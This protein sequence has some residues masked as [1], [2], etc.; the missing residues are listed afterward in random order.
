MLTLVYDREE[1]ALTRRRTFLTSE[2]Q[3]LMIITEKREGEGC[4]KNRGPFKND[5]PRR[6]IFVRATTTTGWMERIRLLSRGTVQEGP[7]PRAGRR[8]IT[9]PLLRRNCHYLRTQPLLLPGSATPTTSLPPTQTAA[10]V[11]V[12]TITTA[13]L[14]SPSPTDNEK[15]AR[16]SHESES[17]KL[18]RGRSSNNTPTL[19]GLPYKIV[20]E[21]TQECT[22]RGQ[23]TP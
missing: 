3:I 13:I 8:L 11:V 20:G 7:R 22:R 17:G 4:E 2:K 19:A 14:Q 16:G 1:D 5:P 12:I 23:R 21:T 18:R 9:I 15:V 10:A 6:I